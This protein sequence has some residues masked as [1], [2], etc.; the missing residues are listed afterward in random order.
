MVTNAVR[1]EMARQTSA[2]PS[3]PAPA[4]TS[5]PQP[6]A[7]PPR[8]ATAREA[9]VIGEL[10]PSSRPQTIYGLRRR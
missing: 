4:A 1:R 5:R 6:D 7:A 8:P 10:E 3:Q 2:A 9:S